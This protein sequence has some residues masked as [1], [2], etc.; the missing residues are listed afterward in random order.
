MKATAMLKMM[1]WT[2]G[3]AWTLC[4][5]PAAAEPGYL[6]ENTAEVAAMGMK[7]PMQATQTCQPKEW[8]EPP[9][10][11]QQDS[12]C[13]M[14]DLKQSPGKVSWKVK[15]SGKAPASGSGEI[16]FQGDTRYSG[17]IKMTTREGES[18]M[19]LTGKRL[20]ACEYSGKPQAMADPGAKLMGQQCQQAVDNLD[21]AAFLHG[22]TCKSHKQAF[23]N[24][25]GSID[26]VEQA[27]RKSGIALGDIAAACGKNA[28]GWC[29]HA[30]AT[31]RLAFVSSHCPAQKGELVRKHCEGR[32]H[33]ALMASQ[34]AD[35]C[36]DQVE[37]PARAAREEH[38]TPADNAAEV[39]K[40][41][42]AKAIESIGEGVQKLKGLL[43]F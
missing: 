40:D 32:D 30:A 26:A 20:G 6:W 15:C 34:Y 16:T 29:L 5:T 21:A 39:M 33:T 22:D 38:A 4:A 43:R 2:A 18:L 1:A 11:Q 24:R 19:K 13:Q 25:M 23:C 14:T 3:V 36:R 41:A 8:R 7:M 9:G 12:D 17:V 35:F 31:D 27:A 28:E 10:A 37:R 42:P